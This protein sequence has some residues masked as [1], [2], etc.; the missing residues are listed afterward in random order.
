MHESRF[1]DSLN[2]NDQTAES[3]QVH[4]KHKNKCIL[5]LT[6]YKKTHNGL[7]D[8]CDRGAEH[9]CSKLVKEEC[10]SFEL[11]ACKNEFKSRPLMC[12][13]CHTWSTYPSMSGT[14]TAW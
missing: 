9:L 4:S 14:L 2:Q 13:Q 10:T 5:Q 8:G 3:I 11:L 6:E 12:V 7:I 1:Q